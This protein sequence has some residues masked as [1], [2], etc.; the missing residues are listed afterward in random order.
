MPDFAIGQIVA[1]IW[2]IKVLAWIH[3]TQHNSTPVMS[4]LLYNHLWI[5]TPFMLHLIFNHWLNPRLT[6]FFSRKTGTNC[7]ATINLGFKLVLPMPHTYIANLKLCDICHKQNYSL[8][9]IK[10][11]QGIQRISI[12]YKESISYI[13]IYSI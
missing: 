7:T 5:S 3:S 1:E 13:W 4:Q 11:T 10:Y 9:S 6:I 2:P 12:F 8:L